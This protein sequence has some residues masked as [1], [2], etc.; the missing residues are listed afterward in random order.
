MNLNTLTSR[1]WKDDE[2]VFV[3]EVAYDNGVIVPTKITENVFLENPGYY[4]YIYDRVFLT[5]ED[6]QKGFINECKRA[7]KV[8]E[9]KIN[10]ERKGIDRIEHEIEILRKVGERLEHKM[11]TI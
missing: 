10:T 9:R 2:K 1:H 3:V 8:V 6:A 11:E 4:S 5:K 7:Q